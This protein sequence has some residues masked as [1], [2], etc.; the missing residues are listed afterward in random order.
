MFYIKIAGQ[1]I[2]K[3][4]NSF[5]INKS[6]AFEHFNYS[7]IDF[8]FYFII[9]CFKIHHLNRSHTQFFGRGKTTGKRVAKLPHAMVKEYYL[10]N[11]TAYPYDIASCGTR[12]LHCDVALKTLE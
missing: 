6:R 10:M 12:L 1:I 11:H 3:L 4:L 8:F 5:A 2:C 7:S 9:L